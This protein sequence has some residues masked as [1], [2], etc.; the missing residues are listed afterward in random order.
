MILSMT[1]Y[2]SAQAVQDGVNFAVEIR[3]VNHRYL[4]LSLKLPEHL[5]FAE[6]D[7][8][9]L[10]RKSLQRGSVSF[11]LK[12]RTE[13][14]AAQLPVNLDVVQGYVDQLSKTKVPPGVQPTIDL[15][16]VAQLPGATDTSQM[17]DETREKIT[18]C[19][20]G[21]ASE[22]LKKLLKMRREE[23][24]ALA[25]DLNQNA[26]QI[27]HLLTAIQ[28]R[29]PLV[30]DEYHERL[31]T[32]V[33]KLLD[34]GQL[35]L[36]SDT[37]AREIA[38]YAERCDIAEEIGRIGSHLD[39]F[40]ELCTR[41]EPVGRTLDFLAQ[42]LLREANTIGSKSGDASISRNVVELKGVIDRLKEQVQNVE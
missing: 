18:R 29:A 3:S 17:D 39:Q 26:D 40:S 30:I 20:V 36:D 19:V 22:A 31:K 5:Q 35:D 16:A 9:S 23:G 41:S 34:A 28:E 11:S 12:V 42:E 15:A 10:L 13:T 7:L 25:A 1:G 6:A 21:A 33:A 8:D 4:K 14:A 24:K 37:L 38:V 2:G 32:R 27:K